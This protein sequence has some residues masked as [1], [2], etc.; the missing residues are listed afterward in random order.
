MSN[1]ALEE[2]AGKWSP[3]RPFC[4]AVT[5]LTVTDTDEIYRS[6]VLVLVLI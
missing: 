5:F 4:E 1:E 3:R 2:A 6:T